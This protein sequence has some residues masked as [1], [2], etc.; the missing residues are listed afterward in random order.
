VRE[1]DRIAALLDDFLVFGRAGEIRLAPVN[2]HRVLDDVLDV[3][4]AEPLGAAARVERAFDPSIPELQADADRLM[5]V[6]LNSAAT[7][8]RP[9]STARASSASAPICASISASTSATA[10]ACPASRST[11]KTAAVAFP[12]VRDRIATPFFTTP[13]G[14]GL[15]LALARHFVTQHGGVLQVESRTG[16]GTRVRVL[17][18]LRRAA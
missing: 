2:L 6:F 1:V 5:Q 12:K 11:S 17:L 3:L 9:C 8:S 10:S 16:Q 14:T 15:G 7:P 18:P 13:R 4:A